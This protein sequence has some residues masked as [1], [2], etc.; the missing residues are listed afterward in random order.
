M[1]VLIVLFYNNTFAYTTNIIKVISSNELVNVT[2][3]KGYL[4]PILTK[5][6]SY[7]KAIIVD[8]VNQHSLPN[9]LPLP[10]LFFLYKKKK[11]Y[12]LNNSNNKNLKKL[13]IE[14][15]EFN[16]NLSQKIKDNYLL[17]AENEKTLFSKV[18][19]ISTYHDTIHKILEDISKIINSD[20]EIKGSQLFSIKKTLLMML[21]NED[22]WKNFKY[23]FEKT[24]PHFY[25]KL[26]AIN[27]NLTIS[28]LKN[29]SYIIARLSS[30]EVSNLTNTSHRSVETSR[31]RLKKKLDLKPDV[32]LYHFL[33]NL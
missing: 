15:K 16:N 18:L 22:V 12:K 17:I 32:K 19:Q 31:Y 9:L 4:K 21:N 28:D 33:Q 10:F 26:L 11:N 14:E 8:K 1:V 23:Q 2:L 5:P 7:T 27:P 30:K 13:L 24:K 20:S 29:C 25:K 6:K 3:S